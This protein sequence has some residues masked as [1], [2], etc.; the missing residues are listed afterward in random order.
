MGA[1]LLESVLRRVAPLAAGARTTDPDLLRRFA[2][3]RDESAFAVLI[4]RHGPMV[5]TVCRNL[6][7]AEADAED[8]FQ[9]TFLAFIRSAG[10]I[11]TPGALGS[12]LYGVAYRV[13]QKARRS[14]ARQR[15]REKSAAAREATLPVAAGS[16]DDIQAAVH[17]EVN[18]LPEPLRTAFVICEIEG[19]GQREA[20]ATLGWKPGTL[21]ARL[22][23][24][25][26]RLLRRLTKQGVA[27]AAVVAGALIS[28]AGS[29]C[30]PHCVT[31]RTLALAR[32]AGN[33]N[34]MISATVL[35]LA[36]RATEV[37]MT[38]TKLIA[39]AVALVATLA[40]GTATTLAPLVTAQDPAVGEPNAAVAQPPETTGLP[41]GETGGYPGKSAAVALVGG[42]WDYKFVPRKTES[43]EDFERL[44]VENGAAGWEYCGLESLTAMTAARKAQWGTSPTIVFKRP[45]NAAR[46]DYWS[47]DSQHAPSG[48]SSRYKALPSSTP[49]AP[50]GAGASPPPPTPAGAPRA[51]SPFGGSEYGPPTVGG[52]S[53]QPPRRQMSIIRLAHAA[54]SALAQT[55]TQVFDNRCR[56]VADQGTNALIVQADKDTLD[57]VKALIEKLDVQPVRPAASD[58]ERKVKPATP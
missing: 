24:A 1:S 19:V 3:Q 47:S 13:A 11:R 20:A 51:S 43:L 28:K 22:T 26:Q 35:N 57:E 6:L 33:V 2:T 44:L 42:Q 15:R 50:S 38:R 25:R 37:S 10:T 36:H 8:A 5:W 27:G 30:T 55:L 14:A 9:A 41:A 56:I 45:K 48:A 46:S 39:A 18:R 32:V 53:P 34:E 23:Q 21:S 29:A 52:G 4:Q 16:W 7:P 17:R 54:S 31:A 58:L 40:I 49:N 12:W